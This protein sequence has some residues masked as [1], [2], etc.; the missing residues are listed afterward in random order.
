MTTTRHSGRMFIL[1]LFAVLVL[2]ACYQNIGDESQPTAI[3]QGLPTATFTPFPTETPTPTATPTLEPTEVVTEEVFLPTE[4][5]PAVMAATEEDTSTVLLMAE[6]V[7]QSDTVQQ[8]DPFILTATQYVLDVTQTAEVSLTQTAFALGLGATPTPTE[9]PTPNLFAPAATQPFT[10]TGGTS[11]FVGGNC[12]HEIRQGENLFRLSLRYGVSVAD[13]AAASGITNYN[14]VLIGQKINVPGCGTT[15]VLPPPTSIPT[16]PPVSAGGTGGAFAQG[17]TGG[18]AA[19]GV[20]RVHVVQQYESLF[21]ISLMYGVSVQ[22]I[23]NANGITNINY[24]VMG[25]ELIIPP[26]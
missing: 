17:A 12:V 21:Q 18:P 7:S 13:L 24:I 4:T 2:S 25:Q 19:G 1:V 20:S 10:T 22:S 9:T 14:L 6:S 15:G 5:E 11:G 23:A 3:S 16:Q 26:R 8:Q